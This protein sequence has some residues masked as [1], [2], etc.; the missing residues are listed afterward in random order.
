[1]IKQRLQ[2]KFEKEV[3]PAMVKEFG[4]KNKIAVPTVTKI[5]VNMGVGNAAK[6]AQGLENL[7]KDFAT[8]AG[9]A[10][11]IR[12]ARVSIASFSLRAGMPVG[13][14]A[15]L[16]GSK[17]YAFMD[18]LFSVTLPRLRDFRGISDKSFDKSGNYTLGLIE[19]TVFPEIDTTKSAAAHGLEITIVIENGDPEKSKKLLELLGCPFEKKEEQK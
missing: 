3:V 19:H 14:S 12:N 16:R 8:I 11:S 17:M 4:I 6:N 2:D 18:R 7:K 1:M 10:P 15:T 5:A 13:L 9:Q